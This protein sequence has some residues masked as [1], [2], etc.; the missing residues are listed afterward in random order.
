M[1]LN[2]VGRDKMVKLIEIIESPKYSGWDIK[3]SILTG[4]QLTDYINN[5]YAVISD[6]K[7]LSYRSFIGFPGEPLDDLFTLANLEEDS[8]ILSQGKP[9]FSLHLAAA[10]RQIEPYAESG[11]LSSV[12]REWI[13]NYSISPNFG[14]FD[15]IYSFSIELEQQ[16]GTYLPAAMYFHYTN[17]QSKTVSLVSKFINNPEK[18]NKEIYDK[19][20]I[21]YLA[22]N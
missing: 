9:A 10:N 22:Q 18:M 4:S 11:Q 17:G 8:T 1:N 3:E 6:E 19:V 21:I 7:T 5:Q 14:G 15:L 12:P 20:K 16:P 13:Y 2:M